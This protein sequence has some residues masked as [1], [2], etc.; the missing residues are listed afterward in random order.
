M[1][2]VWNKFAI[3]VSVKPD[4]TKDKPKIKAKEIFSPLITL[5]M[6]A[7]VFQGMLRDGITTWMP[8]FLAEIYKM[9]SITSILSGVILPVFSIVS[10]GFANR[11][12]MKKF[13]DPISCGGLFFGM[14]TVTALLLAIFGRTNATISIALLAIL[15]GSM[16]GANLM[17]VCMLPPY[18]SKEGHI[19]TLS[20]VL[21]FCTYVGSALSTYGIAAL[22]KSYGW[23][24]VM[25]LWVVI[26]GLG[27]IMCLISQYVRKK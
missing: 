15:T 5:V 7:I 14:G 6:L 17:L 20:G 4:L 25:L 11:I 22:S 26:A 24:L 13:K 12:Y 18:L 27:T 3:D 1:V 19:S 8:T 2:F 10:F 21:N 16:H 9:S 23:N